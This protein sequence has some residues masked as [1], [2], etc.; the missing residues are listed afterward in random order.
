[1]PNSRCT[2]QYPHGVPGAPPPSLLARYR[3]FMRSSNLGYL[4]FARHL[5]RA[6]RDRARVRMDF[7]QCFRCLLMMQDLQG[8]R[9]LDERLLHFR[10]L[11]DRMEARLQDPEDGPLCR[12]CG[13]PLVIA[14]PQRP[15]ARQ[16]SLGTTR[17]TSRG[18]Q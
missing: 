8:I 6:G 12:V 13:Y 5:R 3:F 17:D 1:M 4:V 14:L 18:S 9:S 10:G 11:L 16:Q 15:R 2:P 7:S